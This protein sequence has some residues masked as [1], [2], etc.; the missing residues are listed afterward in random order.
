MKEAISKT[1]LYNDDFPGKLL[2]NSQEIFD[3]HQIANCFNNYFI[4]VGSNLAAK[5]PN[6]KNQITSYLTESNQTLDNNEINYE[7]F[8][9]QLSIP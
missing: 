7:E 8:L 2:V 9:R 1:K 5:I 4:N 3:T 6:N